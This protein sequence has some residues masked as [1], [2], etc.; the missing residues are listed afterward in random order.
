[1]DLG[2][3]IPLISTESPLSLFAYP[4]N[5]FNLPLRKP[6]HGADLGLDTLPINVMMETNEI[7][8]RALCCYSDLTYQR[9][10][11]TGDL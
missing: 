1:M 4:P 10:D 7:A 5:A 2:L 3:Q 9:H 11:K 6:P 8:Q